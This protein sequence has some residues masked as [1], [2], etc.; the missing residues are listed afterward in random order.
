MAS[1]SFNFAVDDS[2]AAAAVPSD[3]TA[4]TAAAPALTHHTRHGERFH[5][6]PRGAS[7]ANSL[8]FSRVQVPIAA[9]APPV[10]FE[11]VNTTDAAFLAQTGT[12]RSI[13]S[14]S[15]LEAGV[16]E[17]GFKLWECSLNLVKYVE[18]L[19]R[20]RASPFEMPRKVMEL[21]CGHGI[22]GIHALQRGAHM[23]HTVCLLCLGNV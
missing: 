14:T 23:S 16:Y 3:T 19:L 8:S 1:F 6:Q 5:W 2:V 12:I 9:D 13:L 15:D 17:G 4:V 21:G 11:L 20:D 22:P 18:L 7:G 10:E